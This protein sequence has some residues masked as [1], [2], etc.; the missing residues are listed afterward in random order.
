MD[1][2]EYLGTRDV[3]L[4]ALVEEVQA[5]VGLGGDDVLLAVGSLVEG[6][7][8]TK[9][10][11]DLV[12]ISARPVEKNPR[13]GEVAVVAGRCLADVCVLPASEIAEMVE[14][15]EA[16]DR[17]P[18]EVS[19]AAR[20]TPK[21]RLLLHRLIRGRRLAEGR[22]GSTAGIPWPRAEVLAKLKLHVARQHSRTVQA[23]MAGHRDAGD[24]RSL[25]FAAQDLL[26]AAM[27]ALTAGYGLTNPY[28]KWRSRLLE[29]VPDGWEAELGVRPT[30]LSAGERVWRLH[31]SP[32]IP[33]RAKALEH[34]FR[35]SAFARSVFVWAERRLVP[36]TGPADA[37]LPVW[38][39]AEPGTGEP[40][41]PFLDFDVD[42]KLMGDMVFLGRLNEFGAPAPL[43]P[44][45]FALALLCDGDTTVREADAVFIGEAAPGESPSRALVARLAAARLFPL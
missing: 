40:R 35:I 32:S 36:A 25:V 26:G 13:G 41:L 20:F 37:D 12:L 8:T 22:T 6:L 3:E 9:S 1:L 7:G 29:W 2:E 10:D 5:K 38:P 24:W 45:E 27:D 28:P 19:H 30:G 44:G 15:A 23:D 11:L 14:R 34:G 17:A 18:W 33:G 43:T 21:E 31:R 39:A 4:R 16:W 42:F